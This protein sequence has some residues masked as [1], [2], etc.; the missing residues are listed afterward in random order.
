MAWSRF[1]FV[2]VV[3]IFW[4][5][6]FVFF[7]TSSS[8]SF[9][10]LFFHRSFCFSMLRFR[11]FAYVFCSLEFDEHLSFYNGLYD[12][13]WARLSPYFF[14]IC[15]G[16]ILHKTDEKLDINIV[17]VTCGEFV[18]FN[19][20]INFYQFRFDRWTKMV[21]KTKTKTKSKVTIF[22]WSGSIPTINSYFVEHRWWFKRFFFFIFGSVLLLIIRS[23]NSLL[24]ETNFRAYI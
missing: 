5:L 6:I 1:Y 18:L 12:Q 13:P 14:G 15:M 17:I 24:M 11:L 22:V 4:L 10:F 20:Y 9:N 23:C 19:L 21:H 8:S 3:V 7:L 2:V 16:Y